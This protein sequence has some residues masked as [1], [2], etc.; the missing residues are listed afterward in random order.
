MKSFDNATASAREGSYTVA[1][2]D[3]RVTFLA[4]KPVIMQEYWKQQWHI[5]ELCSPMTLL[6]LLRQNVNL[7]APV[8]ARAPAVVVL[9]L[10]NQRSVAVVR[11]VICHILVTGGTKGKIKLSI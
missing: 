1:H 10:C 9:F 2:F 3:Q 8:L 6:R 11:Q 7:P 4:K 5:T